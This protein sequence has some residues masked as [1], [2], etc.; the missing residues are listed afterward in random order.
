M[1]RFIHKGQTVS[2]ATEKYRHPGAQTLDKKKHILRCCLKVHLIK[3]ILYCVLMI[4]GVG[5]H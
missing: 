5:K 2:N 3:L 1:E 4:I